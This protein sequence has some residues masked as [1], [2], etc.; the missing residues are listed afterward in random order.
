VKKKLDAAGLLRLLSEIGE[1]SVRDLNTKTAE[2]FAGVNERTVRRVLAD[3]DN[4]G[5]VERLRVGQRGN[6]VRVTESG[7]AHLGLDWRVRARTK[8]RQ[9]AVTERWTNSDMAFEIYKMKKRREVA[10]ESDE[11]PMCPC[12]RNPVESGGL[13]ERWSKE[14]GSCRLEAKYPDWPTHKEQRASLG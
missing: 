13:N 12:G 3:L 11:A 2:R 10:P 8:T 7:Q 4:Q 5:W 1:S 9:F 14:C 6:L